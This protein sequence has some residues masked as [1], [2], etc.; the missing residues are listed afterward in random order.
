LLAGPRTGDAQISR[1]FLPPGTELE[2]SVPVSEDGIAEIA[3][4]GDPGDL[5]REA[6]P[7]VLAQLA[8]TLRQD[9]DVRSF[10]L[11]I[12]GEAVSLQAGVAE[13]SVDYGAD[14]DPAILA[15][16][17]D[18]F[19]LRDGLIVTAGPGSE[20]ALAGPMSTT[21][22]GIG[23]LSVDLPANR[24]AAVS[25]TGREVLIADLNEATGSTDRVFSRGENLLKPV[26]DFGDHL[27]V[28]DRRR[29]GAAVSVVVDGKRSTITVPGVTGTFVKSFLVSR[30]GSRFVAVVKKKST[31]EVIVGRV[32][33][34]DEGRVL[35]VTEPQVIAQGT[36]D[37]LLRVSGLGWRSPTVLT[38]VVRVT[39]DR[40]EIRLL[41][42]DG[43]PNGFESLGQPRRLLPERVRRLTSSPLPAAGVYV[44]TES[45]V[46]DPFNPD[47]PVAFD[48]AI[49]L[50]T[51]VG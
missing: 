3:L 24:V 46:A 13:L 37:D 17:P 35:S 10:R 22:Y 27:W 47:S 49:R 12:G 48:P 45:G 7:M 38:L 43:G 15:A 33:R 11:T 25:G 8:W 39:E 4:Q 42:I 6:A 36:P 41:S 50:L 9:P 32:L 44:T 14:Y 51:Y 19:G 30:D 18:L 31:D 34:D 29:T 23:D 21:K 5:A 1:S 26:W 40:D 28:V 2:L 16:S 20:E